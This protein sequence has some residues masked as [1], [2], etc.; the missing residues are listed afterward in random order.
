MQFC[1]FKSGKRHCCS[2]LSGELRNSRILPFLF[3]IKHDVAKQSFNSEQWWVWALAQS[4][5]KGVG[6]PLMLCNKRAPFKSPVSYWSQF[7]AIVP[8]LQWKILFMSGSLAWLNSFA[9]RWM[10]QV[11][12]GSR[13]VLVINCSLC[14]AKDLL[15]AML[16]KSTPAVCTV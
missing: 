3:S 16:M 6:S 13:F 15:Q 2:N 14:W 4:W 1:W 8:P 9:Y 11:R 10:D 7:S 12:K 5:D